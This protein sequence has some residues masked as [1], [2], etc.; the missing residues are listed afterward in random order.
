MDF[1]TEYKPQT[2]AKNRTFLEDFFKAFNQGQV[3]DFDQITETRRIRAVQPI[4]DFILWAVKH[5]EV[6]KENELEFVNTLCE[7]V[8]F[9]KKLNKSS[10][11]VQNDNKVYDKE[12]KGGKVLKAFPTHKILELIN[13]TPSLQMKILYILMA[14]GGRKIGECLHLFVHDFKLDNERLKVILADPEKS[15]IEGV[16]RIDY[17]KENFNMVPR[18][19]TNDLAQL[20]GWKKPRFQYPEKYES[21]IV[22]VGAV[23]Q[24]LQGLHFEYMNWRKQFKDNPYYFLTEN[25]TPLSANMVTKKF[26]RDCEKIGIKRDSEEGITF[27]GLRFFYCY[28]NARVLKMDKVIIQRLVGFNRKYMVD[29]FFIDKSEGFMEIEQIQGGAGE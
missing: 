24:V 21:E 18:T 26:E 15:L 10:M 9:S 13:R 8:E 29:R 25:G 17:L 3:L 4:R 12:N 1:Y 27:S 11:F 16:R 2:Q 19:K 23:E 20:V 22:F 5:K 7:A 14:F 28:Y 6:V